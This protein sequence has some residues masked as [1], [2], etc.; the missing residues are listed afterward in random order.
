MPKSILSPIIP[1]TSTQSIFDT[2]GKSENNF[3][4][5]VKSVRNIQNVAAKISPRVFN[6]NG[7]ALSQTGHAKQLVILT[8]GG[9]KELENKSTTFRRQV[10]DGWTHVPNG[11]RID[12]Y[13][14]DKNFTKGPSVLSEVNKRPNDALK[15]LEPH[16]GL[17]ESDLVLLAN[18]RNKSVES[19]RD[20][21]LNLAT[22]KK[23][24][25][26]E[27]GRVKDYALYHHENTHAL[28]QQH[29]NGKYSPD[30]DIALVTDKKHKRHLSDIFEAI[31]KSGA[32]Y[33]VIHF[34]AC[35][36]ERS[37]SAV[38]ELA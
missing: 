27:G 11:L 15:G 33:Q 9:W 14:E 35:R 24:G 10:G 16:L 23:D 22:Y 13:T 32:E 38:P 3:S 12:F 37:G 6:H 1:I 26:T 4:K 17:S 2:V 36:V 29:Q 31:K 30:V 8:H 18:S 34:G 19:I 21:M 5:N 20:D 25:V 7:I 28:I